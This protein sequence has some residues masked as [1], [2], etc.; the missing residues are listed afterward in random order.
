LVTL[1]VAPQQANAQSLNPLS[2]SYA[3]CKPVEWL[4]VRSLPVCDLNYTPT[5]KTQTRAVVVDDE[6]ER[7]LDCIIVRESNN[8]AMAIN[9][10]DTDGHPKYGLMQFHYPTFVEC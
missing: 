2:L 4:V 9:P 3:T 7:L 10:M 6:L 5:I 1:V 8:N